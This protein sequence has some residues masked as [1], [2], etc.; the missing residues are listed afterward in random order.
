MSVTVFEQGTVADCDTFGPQ[1]DR[2]LLAE[3][4]W[5]A[6]SGYALSLS[7]NFTFTY[8]N[9]GGDFE[10]NVATSGRIELDAAPQATDGGSASTTLRIRGEYD[11]QNSVEGQ[12][13][14]LVCP[15]PFS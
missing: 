2:E 5:T 12:V 8:P 1:D 10:N 13:Q 11:D 9:D 15:D 7:H 4:P 6:N 14:V 3:V